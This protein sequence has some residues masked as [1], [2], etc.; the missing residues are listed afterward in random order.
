V[1]TF[2]YEPDLKCRGS[3]KGYAESASRYGPDEAF[4]FP[5]GD[6]SWRHY[7]QLRS[8]N[9]GSSTQN[10]KLHGGAH[11]DRDDRGA[12]HH[13]SPWLDN[14]YFEDVYYSHPNLRNGRSIQDSFPTIHELHA[15]HHSAESLPLLG[16]GRLLHA[17]MQSNSNLRSGDRGYWPVASLGQSQDRGAPRSDRGEPFQPRG[18]SRYGDSSR[19]DSRRSM[20]LDDV[21]GGLSHDI[22]SRQGRLNRTDHAPRSSMNKEQDAR[23]SSERRLSSSVFGKEME[24]QDF[25]EVARSAAL[26]SIPWRST[27]GLSFQL[28]L[29]QV[30]E[31]RHISSLLLDDNFHARY[32]NVSKG[33]SRSHN[34]FCC[35]AGC[36]CNHCS[37]P[38]YHH[39]VQSLTVSEANEDDAEPSHR[40]RTLQGLATIATSR[41]SARPS[42]DNDESSLL[43]P[44]YDPNL[45]ERPPR[46][47]GTLNGDEDT[48]LSFAF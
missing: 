45:D 3:N 41:H 36:C 40:G 15:Q 47:D 8:V 39:P 14:Q 42:P 5:R 12:H 27:R 29:L 7:D 24:W 48:L 11:A 28:R 35:S 33:C 19:F 2:F 38:L 16:F 21:F 31:A 23:S 25:T 17:E 34:E 6:L 1:P 10:A 44:T 46:G 26:Q 18:S 43:Y 30:E 32:R 4:G 13:R 22:A 37:P 20:C 9:G